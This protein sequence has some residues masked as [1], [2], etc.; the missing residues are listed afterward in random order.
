[1]FTT[2]QDFYLF[3]TTGCYASAFLFSWFAFKKTTTFFIVTGVLLHALYLIGRAWLGGIFIPNAMVE[4]PFFLPF[5]L[6]MIACG[7][8]IRKSKAGITGIIGLA[9]I[10]SVF[11]LWYAKG[12]IP[13][14]PRKISIWAILFFMSEIMAQALFY[15]GAVYAAILLATK[16]EA[17]FQSFLIWGFVFYTIA[18]VT[19]AI[20]SFLGWGNTFNWSSRHLGSSAV[21]TL[22]AAFLHVRFISGWNDRKQAVFAVVSALFVLFI[23]FSN[24]LHEMSFPRIGG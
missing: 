17:D 2:G 16:Q 18:Q 24:Y 7:I 23:S 6:A 22:Y 5:C 13:P 10:F 19:G 15:S 11:A 3:F 4:G 9:L 14:T 1:M 12:I 8:R 20:W 21:W